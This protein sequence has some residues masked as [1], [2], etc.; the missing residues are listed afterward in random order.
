MCFVW[1]SFAGEL[2]GMEY[3]YSQSGKSL[4]VMDNPEEEDRLVEQM[5]DEVVQDEGFVEEEPEDL[6]VPV[7]YDPIETVPVHS[8]GPQAF[9]PCPSAPGPSSL[10][11]PTSS[12]RLQRP[13]QPPLQSLPLHSA[14]LPLQFPQQRPALPLLHPPLQRPVHPPLQ[15]P[16]QPSVQPSAASAPATFT[17]SSVA[18]QAPVSK[19]LIITFYL[20]LHSDI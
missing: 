6:T 2:L 14:Q 8:S 7:L 18:D 9:N 5:D 11:P 13:A 20:L 3:L 4:T 17:G 15:S 19:L 1:C 16:P 12:Q 10:Q